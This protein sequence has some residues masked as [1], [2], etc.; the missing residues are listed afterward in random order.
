M[1]QRIAGNVIRTIIVESPDRFARDLAVQLAGHDTLKGLGIDLIPASVPDFFLRT[2]RPLFW[3]VRCWAPSRNL[4]SEPGRQLKAAWDRKRAR[5]GGT[6]E[7][8]RSHREMNLELVAMAKKLHRRNPKTGQRVAAGDC[9]RARQPRH[10][11]HA[12]PSL[13]R[14]VDTGDGAALML[15]PVRHPI[16]NGAATPQ[17][18]NQF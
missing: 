8:R 17:S 5:A 11:Q 14:G 3:C 7:G 2:R 15:P 18:S 10:G 6:C 16:V 4:R 1:L 9:C 12:W 13:C